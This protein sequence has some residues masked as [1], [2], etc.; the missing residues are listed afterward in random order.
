MKL[1]PPSIEGKLPACGGDSL[2]IPFMMNRA[3]GVEEVGGMVAT[4]KTI[5]T[6]RVVGALTGSFNPGATSGK[7][8]A[9]FKISDLTTPLN[10]GQFYKV[11]IAYKQLATNEIGYYSNVGIFKKTTKPDVKIPQLE[12]N[13]Y[14]GYEYTGTYSQ[15]GKDETEK[16]YSYCFELS[17]MDGNLIDTS[18]VQI[19]DSSKDS[20]SSSEAQDVWKS[21]VELIKDIPYYIIYKV[22]TINGLEVSSKTYTTINQDSIDVDLDMELRTALNPE[23]G[24]IKL[25]I[26]PK[27]KVN[28]IIS[29]NFI[30]VRASSLN[31]FS[32]WDEVYRFAYLNVTLSE[33]KPILIWEDYSIQQGEEYMYALQAYNGK[34]YSNRMLSSDGKIKVDFVDMFLS[35][36]ERQLKIQFN[37]KVS[38]FKNNVLETKMETI[39]SKYP[40]IFK[41]GYVHYK[42]FSISGLLSMLSDTG[43]T[44]MKINDVEQQT[45][46]I[47]SPSMITPNEALSTDLSADNIY[48][49][50]QFKLEVL[51]WLNNGKPK[52]FRSPAEGNYIVRTM[53]VS[54]SPNDTLG[55]MLHTFQCTA[56][57]IAEWNFKNL[58]DLKLIN[59]PQNKIS[60]VKIAQ[61]QPKQ[62]MGL[63]E[64]EF[65]LKYSIF[66]NMKNDKLIR[67]KSP[68]YHVNITEATPG[69]ILGFTF[70]DLTDETVYI[71]IGG[72]GAYYFQIRDFPL[73]EVELYH[74]RWDEMKITFE[75][76]DFTPTDA[77]SKIADFKTSDEIRRIPGP[78]FTTNLMARTDYGSSSQNHILSDIRREIGIIHYLRAEKRYIQEV[79]RT[80]DGRYSRNQS[81]NDIIEDDE[82]NPILLYHNNSNGKYYSGN[83]RTELI[84]EPDFRLCISDNPEEY[85]D[86]GG[87]WVEN[88]SG[89]RFG[90]SFGRIDALRSID[91][92]TTLRVGN[93]VLV[94]IAYRVRTK[95]YVVESKDKTVSE[96]KAVWEN[97]VNYLKQ[98]I[99]NDNIYIT[100]D[101]INKQRSTVNKTYDDFIVQL[102]LALQR[103]GVIV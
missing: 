20:E 71:E 63:S 33:D 7:Y 69:T 87:N 36:G 94:D 53:N 76:D 10:D 50:R 72:T 66:E 89:K 73:F 64:S 75:Y 83:M 38:N 23:E 2:V 59:I 24:S 98:M 22:T 49:E 97:N 42:E 60:N 100:V 12:D 37:P 11:Q 35:D 3:V 93:G 31:N 6:G 77:F 70:S 43:N 101:D 51:D 68:A 74:G 81:L 56:Y 86:L 67:F 52:I 102:R 96:A 58:S 18:G 28:S 103:E 47:S 48:K 27:D 13:F 62:M 4:I 40:F 21:S 32:S 34:I 15:K 55:R 19:H 39:G 25:S 46:R 78:G 92:L 16:I 65:Q 1:Y 99:Q 84:G 82:W 95:E 41:N 26:K 5:S 45:R 88:E 61:I 14:N 30:L 29:G 79:W 9:S 80:P 85:I 54:L 17:D 90:G 57:E 44:F 91:K 8:S